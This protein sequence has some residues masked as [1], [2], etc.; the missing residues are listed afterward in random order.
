MRALPLDLQPADLAVADRPLALHLPP[1]PPQLA[2]M[3]ARPGA[4]PQGGG[5]IGGPPGHQLGQGLADGEEQG[6]GQDPDQV[7]PAVAD[8]HGA[9]AMG[10]LQAARPAPRLRAV[11]PARSPA[12]RA[13]TVADPRPGRHD[14]PG[15]ERPGPARTG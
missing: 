3:G 10:V 13:S 11:H 15:S 14:D 12:A 2:R 7:E 5:R 9:D 4:R 1:G 6:L 8:E